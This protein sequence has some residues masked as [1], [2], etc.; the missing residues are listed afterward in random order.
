M[1]YHHGTWKLEISSGK[2]SIFVN[3]KK[4]NIGVAGHLF[5]LEAPQGI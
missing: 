1:A 4:K 3:K 2:K 5:F